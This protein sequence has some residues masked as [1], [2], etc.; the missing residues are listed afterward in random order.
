VVR[1]I[2]KNLVYVIG[3]PLESATEENLRRQDM[4]GQY[5]HLSKI[6]IN[7]RNPVGDK[8]NTCGVYLTYDTDEQALACIRAVDGFTYCRRQL[9]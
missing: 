1:V 3:I 5:G 7:S 4:F 9:K 6:V 8:S 2:Q